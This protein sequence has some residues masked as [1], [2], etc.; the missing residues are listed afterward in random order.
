MYQWHLLHS[1][2]P[3]DFATLL[4]LREM[5]EISTPDAE[6]IEDAVCNS[7]TSFSI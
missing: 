4:Q 3:H 7:G 5:L 2:V 6:V 1:E